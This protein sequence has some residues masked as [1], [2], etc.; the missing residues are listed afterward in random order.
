ML[1]EFNRIAREML[2]LH[3]HLT[4]PQDW[5]Q[6]AAPDRN[7]SGRGVE[8]KAATR[9]SRTRGLAK[10]AAACGIVTPTRLIVGQFR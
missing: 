3:G 4:R 6:N 5:A 8:A 2:F 10:A 9:R 7:P 1:N